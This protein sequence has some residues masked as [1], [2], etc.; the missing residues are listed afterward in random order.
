MRN[1]NRKDNREQ[2]A[3]QSISLVRRAASGDSEAFGELYS[4]YFDRIYRY[5][6]YQ[7][8]DKM[9]AEDVTEET[10][11]KAWKAIDSCKGKEKTFSPWLYRIAHNQAIDNLRKQRKYLS[12]DMGD[13]AE[14]GSYEPKEQERLEQQEM[15]AAISDLPPNQKQVII[16]RFIEG[17]SNQEVAQIMG[18]RQGAV[19]MLQTRALVSLRQALG[20]E[21]L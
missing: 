4:I 15:L 2:E 14:A 12:T 8:R 1:S 3:A 19:R 10:F 17:L 11:V 16:L 7:V 18:K 21:E 6:V 13:L 5:V 9:T 20:N